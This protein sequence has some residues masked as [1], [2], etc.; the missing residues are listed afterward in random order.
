MADIP[1]DSF[2]HFDLDPRGMPYQS[3]TRVSW[4]IPNDQSSSRPSSQSSASA[5]LKRSTSPFDT[6]DSLYDQSFDPHAQQQQP[7]IPQWPISQPSH[8]SLTFP[9]GDSYQQPFDSDYDVAYHS[10][11][12][13]FLPAHPQ[14]ETALQMDGSYVPLG[15]QMDSMSLNWP[16]SYQNTLMGCYGSDSLPDLNLPMQNLANNSPTETC[17][18]A[19]SLTSSSSDGWVRVDYHN[20]YQSMDAF[21]DPHTGSISN[22]EQ[23]LHL[24]TFSD[25][26]HSDAEQLSQY[27]GSSYVEISHAVGSPGSDSFGDLEFC[28]VNPR[29]P[30]KSRPSPPAITTSTLPKPIPVKEKKSISP[31]RSPVTIAMS[32]PT[33]RRQSRKNTSPKTTKTIIQRK[34][35]QP[36]KAALE[37]T[38][39]KVGR[40]KGPLRPDQRKQ[41]SE[42]RKLGA[43]LRCKFLKKTV[44]I[45]S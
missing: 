7:F 15:G 19:R 14:L 28:N 1:A 5:N 44:S 35:V 11:P 22:P 26:S 25:S 39:K 24:R 30:I 17:L 13:D 23:T 21:Q 8:S 6:I 41:A 38:E 32:S 36:P 31:R 34:T 42:I 10:S 29:E 37:T 9:F 18:E 4:P 45:L 12:T 27:S 43:C 2:L 40:R 16:Q 33:N 3:T 20:P